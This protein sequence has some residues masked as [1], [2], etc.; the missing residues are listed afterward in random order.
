MPSPPTAAPAPRS[1]R[2]STRSRPPS[3]GAPPLA[4]PAGLAQDE[5][6]RGA[7]H[8][9][10]ERP[11]QVVPPQ[12]QQRERLQHPAPLSLPVRLLP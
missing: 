9:D 11:V 7:E 2:T 12:V 10:E 5:G 8:S 6:R 3:T 1:P 4:G